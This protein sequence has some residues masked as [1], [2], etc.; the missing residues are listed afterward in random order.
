METQ[1][2]V[3]SFLCWTSKLKPQEE[4][5]EPVVPWPD[6][7]LMPQTM[8]STTIAALLSLSSTQEVLDAASEIV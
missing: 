2:K 5:R 4:I 3:S 6:K 8:F 1:G 7:F